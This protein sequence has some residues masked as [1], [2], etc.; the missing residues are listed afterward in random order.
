MVGIPAS[1]CT[2]LTSTVCVKAW[3]ST[4]PVRM[5]GTRIALALL[6]SCPLCS[7]WL[8]PCRTTRLKRL[9]SLRVSQIGFARISPVSLWTKASS[10]P[11]VLCPPM[12]GSCSRTAVS[13]SSNRSNSWRWMTICISSQKGLSAGV[14]TLTGVHCWLASSFVTRYHQPLRQPAKLLLEIWA[15]SG[16]FS[17]WAVLPQT[18]EQ[19]EQT[20]R[21]Y[22]FPAWQCWG[23]ATWVAA[24]ALSGFSPPDGRCLDCLGQLQGAI[25]SLSLGGM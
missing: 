17:H 1:T 6:F 4:R 9:Q 21:Q 14:A 22:P 19:R 24:L 2:C 16:V 25:Q 5:G 15:S 10:L 8:K 12:V 3:G 7:A 18:G 23:T 20:P 11:K 13:N